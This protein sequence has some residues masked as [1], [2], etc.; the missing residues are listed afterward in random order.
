MEERKKNPIKQF[1]MHMAHQMDYERRMHEEFFPP[2]KIEEIRESGKYLRDE[3]WK[4][5]YDVHTVLALAEEYKTLS[6]AD[7]REWVYI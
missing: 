5:G 4:K 2:Y 1:A 7:Y 3:M 6:I